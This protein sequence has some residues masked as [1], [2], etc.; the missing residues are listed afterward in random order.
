MEWANLLKTA[1]ILGG[2]GFGTALLCSVLLGYSVQHSLIAF[3][4]GM[5]D[6]GFA[7]INIIIAI[8]T[9]ADWRERYFIALTA[10]I[11]AV[12]GVL[13]ILLPNDFHIR[14]SYI[15]RAAVYI[16]IAMPP[17]LLLAPGWLIITH[18]L[19]PAIVKQAALENYQE[20]ALYMMCAFVGAVSL[21]V[22]F[23]IAPGNTV[24]EIRENGLMFSISVWFFTGILAAVIGI[25][26]ERKSDKRGITEYDMTPAT[27][28]PSQTVTSVPALMPQ[29]YGKT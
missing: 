9:R 25:L 15:D 24:R 14:A 19:I 20:L 1:C 11:A 21:G 17:A 23:P 22:V 18:C 8:A 2:L 12:G 6:S 26:I 4:W 29:A 10:I 27:S 7:V 5:I 16:F 28:R 13:L 3:L